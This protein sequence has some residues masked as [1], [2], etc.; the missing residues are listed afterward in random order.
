MPRILHFADLH[1]GAPFR[2]FGPRGKLLREGLKKTLEN[3]IAAAQKERADLVLCAGDLVDANQVSPA[4]VDFIA[5][6]VWQIGRTG[7]Y[8]TRHP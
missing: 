3:I 2:Q 5:A 6:H 4:T 8:S 7:R 1:L